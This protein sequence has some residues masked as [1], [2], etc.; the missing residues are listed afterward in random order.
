MRTTIVTAGL[1]MALSVAIPASAATASK[2]QLR[3]QAQ[4][5]CSDDAMRLCGD[6]VADEAQASA[7]MKTHRAQLSPQCQKAVKA[8][9]GR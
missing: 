1:L 3:Q 9:G 4:A 5:L 2:E 7:C 6:V 8:M